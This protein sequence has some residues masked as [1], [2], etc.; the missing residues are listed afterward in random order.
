MGCC[1]EVNDESLEFAK[2]IVIMPK[3]IRLDVI[4]SSRSTLLDFR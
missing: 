3:S 2:H 1:G 4:F